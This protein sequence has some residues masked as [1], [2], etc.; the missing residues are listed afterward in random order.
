LEVAIL[1]M[2]SLL[3]P[4]TIRLGVSVDPDGERSLLVGG[5]D[6]DRGSAHVN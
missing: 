2:A 3:T 5:K 4:D 1:A 6:L